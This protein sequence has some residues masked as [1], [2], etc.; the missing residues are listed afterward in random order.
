MT[1]AKAAQ[2]AL[3]AA[4]QAVAAV[5]AEQGA[6]LNSL[7]L[8]VDDLTGDNVAL[9]AQL[10][11]ANATIASLTAKLSD[12][13]TTIIADTS[14]KVDVVDVIQSQLKGKTF[15]PVGRYLVSPKAGYA[16]LTLP[17]GTDLLMD[18]NA[19]LVM[20]PNALPRYYLL[21]AHDANVVVE[22]GQLLGD[23]LQHDYSSGG[24]HEW[25]FGFKVT[26]TSVVKAKNVQASMFTGDGFC[27]SGA[28]LTLENC[29][30]RFNRRQGLSGTAGTTTVLGGEYTDTGDYRDPVTKVLLS[31]GTKP[32]AGIDFEP[33]NPDTVQVV[34]ARV[35]G[36]VIARNQGAGIESH[37]GVLNTSIEN[38]KG[39]A[40]GTGMVIVGSKGGTITNSPLTGRWGNL[41]FGTDGVPATGWTVDTASASKISIGTGCDVVVK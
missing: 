39:D 17:T 13:R 11:T 23:R 3:T 41:R 25:G 36:A 24:T 18:P 19:V 38:C 16:A 26:G 33:D 37:R 30:S 9:Q 21:W 15:L 10:D 28:S 34:N 4:A 2:D 20:K 35:S 29:I 8:L 5:I 7:S 31:T 32:M 27:G 12:Q 6:S 1:D 22:G 40:N 14:G